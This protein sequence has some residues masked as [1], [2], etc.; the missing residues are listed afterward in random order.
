MKI[1]LFFLIF[2]LYLCC[3]N[4]QIL[5]TINT[6][7]LNKGNGIEYC[8]SNITGKIEFNKFR[9][10]CLG[11]YHNKV[12]LGQIKIVV[13]HIQFVPDCFRR[14]ST[15]E[16]MTDANWIDLISK[17]DLV[18]DIFDLN[19]HCLKEDADEFKKYHC[20]CKRGC[21]YQNN[22]STIDRS[23]AGEFKNPQNTKYVGFSGCD[24][25][26][27]IK[28]VDGLFTVKDIH[29]SFYSF[30]LKCGGGKRFFDLYECY[31]TGK[32]FVELDISYLDYRINT[33]INDDNKILPTISK[34]L[35]LDS[36]LKNL[37]FEGM[38]INENFLIPSFNYVPTGMLVPVNKYSSDGNC[39]ATRIYNE[40]NKPNDLGIGEIQ[41]IN[42]EDLA[43]QTGINLIQNFSNSYYSNERRVLASKKIVDIIPNKNYPSLSNHFNTFKIVVPALS[44]MDKSYINQLP[45]TDNAGYY[46]QCYRFKDKKIITNYTGDFKYEIPFSLL[47]NY[48]FIIQTNLITPKFDFCDSPIGFKNIE[49]GSSI[50]I[51]ISNISPLNDDTSTGSITF[52]LNN[53]NKN[54]DN[55]RIFGNETVVLFGKQIKI[56]NISFLIQTDSGDRM[57]LTLTAIG[58]EGLE[59]Y[60]HISYIPQEHKPDIDEIISVDTDTITDNNNGFRINCWNNRKSFFDNIGECLK[61]FIKF[62]SWL[63]DLILVVIIIIIILII[64]QIIL[65]LFTKR[66]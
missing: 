48:N 8:S 26:F 43:I 37:K 52:K 27:G 61:D 6:V 5:S 51:G 2:H 38:I 28:W 15:C 64:L 40:L 3:D 53:I 23:C 21:R 58:N 10:A 7:C 59:D 14:Y 62:D 39:Y 19:G 29:S 24:I 65:P 45:F 56:V 12:L 41:A 34:K 13:N 57:N 16:Y 31:Q 1:L 66:K 9:T 17:V 55:I 25:G 22:G 36:S 20:I 42:P 4:T 49:K 32:Y 30:G 44:N 11:I 35:I 18:P 50:L 63:S 54:N 46:T 60:C 47:E 33:S